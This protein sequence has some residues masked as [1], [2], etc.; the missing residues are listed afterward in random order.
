MLSVV[1]LHL[2][3]VHSPFNS[4]PKSLQHNEKTTYERE[5]KD[6]SYSKPGSRYKGIKATAAVILYISMSKIE[7]KK[8]R[9]SIPILSN[10]QSSL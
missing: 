2:T 9:T 5:R 4:D 10:L 7:I 3:N 6:M 1:S 8:K